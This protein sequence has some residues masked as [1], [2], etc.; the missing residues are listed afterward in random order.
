MQRELRQADPCQ[1]EIIFVLAIHGHGKHRNSQREQARKTE[2]AIL[3][4]GKALVFVEKDT[5][6]KQ[7][8]A[9]PKPDGIQVHP[10]DGVLCKIIIA[11]CGLNFDSPAKT[12]CDQNDGE[13]QRDDTDACSQHSIVLDDSVIDMIKVHNAPPWI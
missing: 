11:Q 13:C 12:H 10:S 3:V 1:Q 8:A 4:F 2:P 9:K 6:D 5:N 7:D